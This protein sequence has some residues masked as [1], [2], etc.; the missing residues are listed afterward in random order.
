MGRR[1]EVRAHRVVIS[2]AGEHIGLGA[3]SS[4]EAEGIYV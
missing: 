2:T 1:S 3:T 4:F